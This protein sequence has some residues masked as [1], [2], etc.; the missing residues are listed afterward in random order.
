[1]E[2]GEERKKGMRRE[3]RIHKEGG[4]RKGGKRLVRAP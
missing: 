1:M 3:K 4:G 2:S